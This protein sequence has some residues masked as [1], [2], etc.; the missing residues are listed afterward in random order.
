MNLYP[1]LLEPILREASWSK[2]ER[3]KSYFESEVGAAQCYLLIDSEDY[4]TSIL[5]G[6]YAGETLSALSQRDITAL[7][8]NHFAFEHLPLEIVIVDLDVPFVPA[9]SP[10]MVAKECTQLWHVLACDPRATLSIGIARHVPQYQFVDGIQ[11]N[12]N[13]THLLQESEAFPGDSYLIQ[14]GRV[15]AASEGNL[16]LSVHQNSGEIWELSDASDAQKALIIQGIDFTDK[17]TSRIPTPTQIPDY[18]RRTP[19]ADHC[20]HFSFDLLEL[21]SLWIEQTT[22]EKGAHLLLLLQGEAT[23]AT[24]NDTLLLTRGKLVFIPAGL[25]RYEIRVDVPARIIKVVPYY[26]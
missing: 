8:G 6:T 16:L 11:N 26:G 21:S 5:N 4:S 3:Y 25:G 1:M 17:N 23:V 20:R 24:E 12:E 13:I 18:N 14:P 2:G 22:L 10:R 15:H 19:I 7:W 9:L